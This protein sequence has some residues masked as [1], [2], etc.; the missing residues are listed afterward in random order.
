[1]P[2]IARVAIRRSLTNIVI[3]AFSALPGWRNHA[4]PTNVF[5]PDVLRV[6]QSKEVKVGDISVCTGE[7]W[8]K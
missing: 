3:A 1:M 8:M 5:L 2:I 4:S 7:T 6:V